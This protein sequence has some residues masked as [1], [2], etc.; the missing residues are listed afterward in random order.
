MK[1][2]ATAGL[3][4]SLLLVTGCGSDERPAGP[5]SAAAPDAGETQATPD[6]SVPSPEPTVEAASG[7]VL[8]HDHARVRLPEGWTQEHVAEVPWGLFGRDRSRAFGIVSFTELPQQDS[9][10]SLDA[11]ARDFAKEQLG[12]GLERRAD[13]AL[14]GDTVALRLSGQTAKH[15]F[16]E[17]IGT[18]IAGR[19]YKLRFDFT[20]GTGTPAERREVVD[21]VIASWEFTG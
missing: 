10:P 7:V 9:T 1:V 13:V 6:A 16:S 11:L 2:V 20:L 3:V 5:D 18:L 15:E 8:A 14:G 19:E 21:S 17:V 12:E 4:V